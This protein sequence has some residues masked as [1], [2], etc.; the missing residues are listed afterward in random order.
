MADALDRLLVFTRFP[1][2][3]TSKTRLIPA[4]GERG[5]ADLHRRLAEATLQR[6]R[7]FGERT[8]VRVEVHFDGASVEAMREWLGPGLEC[9]PQKGEGLGERLVRA[10]AREVGSETSRT[11]VVGTDCPRL[12]GRILGEAFAALAESPVV[13]GP[14]VDG[15]Y[16]LIGLRTDRLEVAL[17]G[18]FLD[19]AWGTDVVRRQTLDAAQRLGLDVVELELLHDIDRPADLNL[20]NM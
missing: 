16:Y 2:P 18:L 11:V 17:P 7:E 19:I 1:V 8:G 14:A 4:L 6:V 3:G 12:D 9:F 10:L 15:G 5:A 20:L 13:L